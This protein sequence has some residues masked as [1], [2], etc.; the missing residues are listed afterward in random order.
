MKIERFEDI[1]IW[2]K[3]R[4]LVKNIYQA[5]TENQGFKGDF[6]LKDQIRR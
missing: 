2:Q 1:Q 5:T 6:A 3:A 4:Q